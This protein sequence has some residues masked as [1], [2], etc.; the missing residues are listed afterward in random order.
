MLWPFH[1][2]NMSS[3]TNYLHTSF[4]PSQIDIKWIEE[5]QPI[6]SNIEDEDEDI[7]D[8]DDDDDANGGDADLVEESVN[9]EKSITAYISFD[10]YL[11]EVI[12]IKTKTTKTTTDK[13]TNAIVLSKR[14]LF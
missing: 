12:K 4:D 9:R 10:D 13:Q 5:D 8:D 6:Q 2:G 11:F 14:I 7:D 3:F 1:I